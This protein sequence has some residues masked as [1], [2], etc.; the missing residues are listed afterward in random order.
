MRGSAAVWLLGSRDRIPLRTCIFFP[1]PFV[2]CVGRIL[3]H[4]LI[5]KTIYTE[6][7]CVCNCVRVCYCMFVS[8]SVCRRILKA[9]RPRH[10]FGCSTTERTLNYELKLW[11]SFIRFISTA[12]FSEYS[13]CHFISEKRKIIQSLKLH[14]FQNIPVVQ[15]YTSSNHCKFIGNIPENHFVKPFQLF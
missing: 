8:N 7:V 10:D 2:C 3:E 15:L 9:R 13:G 6:C 5:T 1:M 14:F 11:W 4:V 12:V